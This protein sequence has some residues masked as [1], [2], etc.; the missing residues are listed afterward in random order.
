MGLALQDKGDV[1]AAIKA[2][3]K[4]LKIDGNYAEA[5][6][7]LGLTLVG[8]GNF[9]QVVASNRRALQIRPDYAEAH[10]QLAH[11]QRYHGSEQHLKQMLDLY[12]RKDLSQSDR[13]HLNFALGQVHDNISDFD[14]AVGFFMREIA[15]ENRCSGITLKQIASCFKV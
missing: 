4:A 12:D 7:N 15:S 6:N 10:S 1:D 3:E 8:K 14:Q 5:H 13:L 2:Y 11:A 9:S